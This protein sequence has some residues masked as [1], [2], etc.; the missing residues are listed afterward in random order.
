M[1]PV[2]KILLAAGLLAA[3]VI[4]AGVAKFDLLND[5]INIAGPAVTAAELEGSWV[6]PVAGQPGREEGFELRP[7]GAAASINMATM[8]YSRWSMP[9][10]GRLR[11]RYTSVGNKVSSSGDED[12][13]IISLGKD[14]LSLKDSY[15]RQLVLSRKK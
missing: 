8:L 6:G 14:R 11:L 7:G 4:A 10:P 9:G 13:S 3:L 1:K 15:G 12:Y 5:D 2:A